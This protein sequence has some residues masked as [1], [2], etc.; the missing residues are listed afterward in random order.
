MVFSL[1]YLERKIVISA[2][3]TIYYLYKS[4]ELWI[5]YSCTQEIQEISKIYDSN[6]HEAGQPAF[7]I[8]SPTPET[9]SRVEPETES[10]KVF[11]ISGN[12]PENEE[13]SDENDEKTEKN[14]TPA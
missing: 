8:E 10:E 6:H 11:T 1:L 13:K 4:Y 7:I 12:H 5:A 3:F 2:I 14:E 9:T